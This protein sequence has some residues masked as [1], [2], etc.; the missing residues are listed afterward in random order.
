MISFR[1]LLT[2]HAQITLDLFRTTMSRVS[3]Q[4]MI[5]TSAAPKKEQTSSKKESIAQLHGMTLSSVCSLSLLPQPLLQFNLHL[6]SYTSSEIHKNKYVAIHLLPPSAKSV[7]LG[8]VFSSGIKR[9]KVTTVDET[10]EGDGDFHEM[11]TPFSRL[12]TEDWKYYEISEEIAIPILQ[13]HESVM[14][15]EAVKD[16]QVGNHEIWV[17][18]VLDILTNKEYEGEKTGG[19]IYFDRHFH[20]IGDQ[21]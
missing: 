21:L 3:S 6:P 16:I 8:R 13:E 10:G 18:K 1:R 11:T 15:C 9:E 2:S 17:V 19:L 7:K 20:R 14:I 5:L 4:A 12:K